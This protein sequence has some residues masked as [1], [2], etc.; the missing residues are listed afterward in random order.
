MKPANRALRRTAMFLI[1]L[2]T[3]G[4][5]DA[6]AAE[7]P[8]QFAVRLIDHHFEPAEIHVPAGKP[9]ILMVTNADDAT[10]EFDSSALRVEKVIAGGHYATIRVP[11]LAAGRYPFMGEFHPQTAQGVVVAQ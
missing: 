6:S 4:R 9:C 7:N 8:V 5:F 3:P 1:L 2:A 11:S 10:E